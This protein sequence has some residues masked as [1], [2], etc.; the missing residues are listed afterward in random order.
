[1]ATG[2]SDGSITIAGIVAKNRD[3]DLDV[4]MSV[5]GGGGDGGCALIRSDMLFL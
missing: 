4:G 1:M 2:H 5:G 3:Q